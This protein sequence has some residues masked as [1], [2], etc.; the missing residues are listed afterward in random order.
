MSISWLAPAVL[1]GTALVAVPIAIHLLVRQQGRRVAYPSLRFVSPSALAAFRRRTVQDA[2]LLACRMAIVVA[3]VLALAGPVL[4]TEAR[5]A[6][7]GNR[8]AR[9][10]I[11][12]PGTPQVA[13]P[14]P[15][16]EAFVW[17]TFTR[18]NPDDAI[19][20][21]LRWLDEQPP[22]SREVL[23]TGAARRGQLTAAGLQVIPPST[24]IRFATTTGAGSERDVVLPILR[25]QDA[26]LVLEQRA[27]HLADDETRVAAGPSTPAP[28]DLLRIEAAP[29]DRA[30]ADAAVRAALEDGVRWSQPDRRV[31][32]AWEGADE[33]AVQR[34]A[35]G[36]TLIRMSRPEPASSAA[37]AV[38]AAVEQVTAPPSD[39]LEPVRIDDAQL[40]A[41]SRAPGGVP[42]EARPADEGD[43]RWFWALALALLALEHVLRRAATR[44]AAAEATVEGDVEARV[45]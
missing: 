2:A 11:V 19:A 13:A 3:A 27:V 35:N 16:G 44:P 40:Q 28:D 33:A 7:H 45:A 15:A 23:F 32:V 37:S 20:E 24:G 8:V 41:W 29:A 39:R 6:A 31:L 36:A 9:A 12:L 38:I 21:A 5:S 14:D 34:V 42:A 10:V 18:A 26:A 25:R 22:A 17:R 30:L 1:L 4:Q 43:R